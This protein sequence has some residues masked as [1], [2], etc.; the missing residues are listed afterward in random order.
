[1]INNEEYAMHRTPFQSQSDN[2]PPAF[3]YVILTVIA[4]FILFIYESII[5]KQKKSLPRRASVEACKRQQANHHEQTPS[6]N[7]RLRLK[8]L[9]DKKPATAAL[10]LVTQSNQVITEFINSAK[11]R[12]A[13]K[14]KPYT[15]EDLTRDTLLRRTLKQDAK[16][17][18]KIEKQERAAARHSRMF[19]VKPSSQ[20]AAI[21]LPGKKTRFG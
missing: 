8:G 21:Q 9:D 15:N 4:C 12:P 18:E 20:Q 3:D 10:P 6:T 1:M 13:R 2:F 16:K 11:N 5:K 14:A 7:T 17:I 19:A